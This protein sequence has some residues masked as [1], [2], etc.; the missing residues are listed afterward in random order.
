MLG[1]PAADKRHVIMDPPHDVTEDRPQLVKEVLACLTTIW[2]V[3]SERLR[4]WS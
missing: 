2:A 1:T 3:S 4:L